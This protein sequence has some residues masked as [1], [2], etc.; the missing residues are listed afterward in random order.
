MSEK[1]TQAWVKPALEY[2]PILLFFI[3]YLTLKDREFLV[4]ETT[5]SGFIVV[6]A[7]FVPLLTLTTYLTWRFTGN[8]SKMQIVTLVLVIVFGGLT[9]WLNDER[10]FKMKPTIIYLIF[11]GILGFGLLRGKSWLRFV[12]AEAVPLTDVGW[13]VLTVRVTSLFFGLAVANEFVWRT[14]SESTW[15][16]FKTFGLPIIIFAFFMLHTKFFE[17]HGASED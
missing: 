16:S 10:F 5:Y 4:G 14:M 9:V 15:V 17:Q 2:G 7:L 6:T 1:D 13:R 3:G 8:L 11:G 12:L